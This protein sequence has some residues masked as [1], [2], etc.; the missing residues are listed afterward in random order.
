MTLYLSAYQ[1]LFSECDKMKRSISLL[2]LTAALLVSAAAPVLAGGMAEPVMEPVITPVPET[3]AE[4]EAWS[5]LYVGATLGYA[6]NG[7]DRLGI[8]DVASG[9]FLGDAD[10]LKV[11]GANVGLRIG[12]RW[13]TGNWVIGPELG[14]EGGDISDSVTG[15]V[16]N[17][18]YTGESQVNSLL[19]LRLKTG[20][21]TQSD[22]M[23]FGTL[24]VGR[25]DVDYRLNGLV[26]DYKTTGY[27]LGLGVEKM[28]STDWSL[29][30]ELEYVG[31]GKEE[32]IFDDISTQATPSYTNVKVGLNYRF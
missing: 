1:F 15:T 26:G 13:Q 4:V 32:R 21:V 28:L 12:Y 10:N 8:R 6:F 27:I 3:P 19:A 31:L 20:Y 30:G 9:E 24:G 14:Y 18:E 22:M 16:A 17:V 11:S 23:V 2:P 5:G 29:T 7:D 25:A